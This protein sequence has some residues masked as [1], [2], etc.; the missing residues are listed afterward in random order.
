MNRIEI[1]IS[2]KK[3][4]ISLM[5]CLAFVLAGFLFVFQ[6]ATFA[7]KTMVS[8]GSM[9]MVV[10]VLSILF[11]GLCGYFIAKK[12]FT[13]TPGLIIDE[14]GISDQS[15][16]LDAGFI[17]WDDISGISTF[18]IFRQQFITVLLKDPQKYIDAE[19]NAAKSKVMQANFRAAGTPYCISTNTLNIKFKALETLL[20]ERLQ[21][22]RR[23]A[24]SF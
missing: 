4:I 20:S 1:S 11:F 12:I 22:S 24:V 7:G 18:K 16:G 10:G 23:A 17:P 21:Q 2:K 13:R 5:G 19:S 3:M 8:S 6:P 15:S 14:K 9:I